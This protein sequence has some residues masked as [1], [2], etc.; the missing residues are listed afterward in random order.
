MQREIVK[1]DP[2]DKIVGTGIMGR[3]KD[4]LRKNGHVVNTI[5]IDNP[6]IAVDGMGGD[7]PPATIVGR[8]GSQKFAMR[9]DEES[10]FDIEKHTRALNAKVNEFSGIFGETWSQQ[11]IRGIDEAKEYKSI[12]DR[13]KLD[14]NV[15][16]KNG[17]PNFTGKAKLEQE[18]WE[19]WSTISKLI[20]KKDL[21]NT[22]RDFFFT[23]LG[24]WDHH[25]EMKDGL[26]T[27][28]HALNF[29]LELFVKEAKSSGFWDNIAV[30]IASDFG[31]TFTP[32][33]YDCV[34]CVVC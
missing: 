29:G 4:M 5:S 20:Q 24:S 25:D 19:K 12:M 17:K 9:P 18:H 28:L 21:R 27:Q 16:T 6:S 30:V 31:R 15:W 34:P 7:S 22:D 8:R 33:R 32:N 13:A 26:R 10:E 3:A 23:E 1:V 14:E 2:Y 11:L